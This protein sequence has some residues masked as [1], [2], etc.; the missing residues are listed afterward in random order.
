MNR[1]FGAFTFT[2]SVL[3]ALAGCASSPSKSEQPQAETPMTEQ[4]QIDS[5]LKKIDQSTVLAVNAQRELAMTADAKV[6]HE[7]LLRKR[8]LT[9]VVD[10]DFFGDV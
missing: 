4:Q 7:A 9:D 10:F 6:A 2:A 1:N 5:V 3:L 8:M